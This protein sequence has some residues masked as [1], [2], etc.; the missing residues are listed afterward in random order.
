MVV[1]ITSQSTTRSGLCRSKRRKDPTQSSGSIGRLGENNEVNGSAAP[2]SSS[3]Q[4]LP[5]LA[6]RARTKRQHQDRL[7]R[8]LQYWIR[9]PIF[10]L[11][12]YSS[13][14][15]LYP[16][17]PS[18]QSFSTR[19]CVCKRCV[20]NGSAPASHSFANP[21]K[22]SFRQAIA[23]LP[24]RPIHTRYSRPVRCHGHGYYK[25]HAARWQLRL[26]SPRIAWAC[27]AYVA[28]KPSS[29]PVSI[30]QPNCR[31]RNRNP[32][33]LQ[34][35]GK[36]VLIDNTHTPKPKSEG[37]IPIPRSFITYYTRPPLAIPV[38][39]PSLRGFAAPAR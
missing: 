34:Q 9:Q 15:L 31:R 14:C 11:S 33:R 35:Y 24:V 22:P 10:D 19:P 30:V 38:I 21:P 28:S 27:L 25:L 5:R 3:K 23:V 36:P 8:R 16:P 12:P 17:W 2:P 4:E 20:S 18:V 26:A 37:G 13:V 7:R 6:R 39:R 32:V 1:L 29:R